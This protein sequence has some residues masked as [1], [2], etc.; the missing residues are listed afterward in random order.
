MFN[1]CP[2]VLSGK[3]VIILDF[4]DT[5]RNEVGTWDESYDA[6]RD[7]LELFKYFIGGVRDYLV[8][9]RY[10]G[11]ITPFLRSPPIK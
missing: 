9:M 1:G 8:L 5:G 6:C 4:A 11:N 2:L 10:G 3:G 7:E